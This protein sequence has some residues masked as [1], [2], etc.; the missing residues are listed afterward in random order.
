[1][2]EVEDL[3]EK[4]KK[5]EENGVAKLY[6]ALSRKAW[7]MADMLNSIN[8]R[9]LA[10]DDPKDKT[11]ERMRF[12]INDSSGIAIAVKELGEAAG[13]TGNEENDIL[14]NRRRTTPESIANVLGN[15]GRQEP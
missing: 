8:L 11:F 13:I 15:N 2:D 14:N 3:K 5:Y 9:N 1:M 12:I 4:V 7:E 10:L 6:Y